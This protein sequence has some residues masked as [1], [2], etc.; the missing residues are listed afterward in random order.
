MNKTSTRVTL[1]VDLAALADASPA[2]AYQRLQALGGR[3]LSEQG[4]QISAGES[5]SQL[6]NRRACFTR[7]RRLL[8]EASHRPPVRKATRPS[9]GAVARRLEGKRQRSERKSERL[10]N[11]RGGE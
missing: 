10:D 3:Y 1:A 4:L 11:R 9:R 6:A 8:V 2:G 7:L 5:R